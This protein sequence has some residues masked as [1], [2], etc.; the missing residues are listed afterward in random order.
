MADKIDISSW[1]FAATFLLAALTLMVLTGMYR[2][3][4]QML[5]SG[6]RVEALQDSS[7]VELRRLNTFFRDLVAEQRAINDSIRAA[8][9][10]TSGGRTR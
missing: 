9:D 10:T 2:S 6:V 1:A 3:Q 4:G 7:V 8:R 5:E